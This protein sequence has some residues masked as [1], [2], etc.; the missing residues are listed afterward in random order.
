MLTSRPINARSDLIGLGFSSSFVIFLF[1]LLIDFLLF[2]FEAFPPRKNE[3]LRL[4]I[5]FGFKGVLGLNKRSLISEPKK[6]GCNVN[7]WGVEGSFGNKRLS[8][9]RGVE[10]RYRLLLLKILAFMVKQFYSYHREI[11][12]SHCGI[13]R[14]PVTMKRDQRSGRRKKNVSKHRESELHSAVEVL[15]I[16]ENSD[17]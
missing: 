17:D 2:L 5:F 6:S 1:N 9:L 10:P 15:A 12:S 4:Y 7:F 3:V 16:V 11:L 8:T 13:H 14:P